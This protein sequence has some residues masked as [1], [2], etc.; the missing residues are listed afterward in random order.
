MAF[1]VLFDSETVADPFADSHFYD[2]TKEMG[3]DLCLDCLQAG[4]YVH[5]MPLV[6]LR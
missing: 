3:R 1:E 2:M 5:A 4:N 6:L